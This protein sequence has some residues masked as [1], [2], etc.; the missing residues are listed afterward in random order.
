MLAL[1]LLAWDAS[2]LD[3]TVTRW[4][5]SAHGF[6][7][8]HAWL[9]QALLHEGGRWA[10]GF[11]LAGLLV[12][13]L[14]PVVRRPTREERL[15]A[16]LSTAACM[17]AVPALK[18]T[19]ATSC[20]WDVA[21]FGGV[22][23]YVSHWSLG[24]SDGGPGHCFPSGHAVAAFA[25]LSV[26]FMLRNHR[27]AAARAWLGAI[28][29]VGLMF[30]WTQ[31]AR[32]AHYLSHA[33][34]SAWV[35][36]VICS[37]ARG[38]ASGAGQRA[39]RRCA[40]T[41]KAD[42]Q[43]AQRSAAGCTSRRCSGI[44]SPQSMQFPYRFASSRCNAASTAEASSASRA[45]SASSTVG[46]WFSEAMSLRSRTSGDRSATGREAAASPASSAFKSRRR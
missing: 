28:A 25:F 2:G 18:L 3:L 20:P 31:L 16:V 27:P 19:S 11:L 8:R 46:D 36:W 1:L 30:A 33:L 35:C 5:G 43:A 39:P 13:A 32:G 9:T 26:Y 7:W 15:H 4:F 45:A 34:W 44:D 10:A 23:R 17:L 12:D 29:L 37:L 42:W 38:A 41:S 40:A 14:H 6:P 22:A 24:A 21:E